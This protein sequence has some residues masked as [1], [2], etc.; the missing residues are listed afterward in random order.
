MC[1]DV[2]YNSYRGMFHLSCKRNSHC[3]LCRRLGDLQNVCESFPEGK[4][5]A[6]VLVCIP[7]L[8]VRLFQRR[9]FLKTCGY[10]VLGPVYGNGN[11]NWR[12]LTNK[13]IY[14]IV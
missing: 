12:I 1:R 4:F 2:T 11:E 7:S 8:A 13:E 5:S 14:T 10:A 3:P 9:I 6:I